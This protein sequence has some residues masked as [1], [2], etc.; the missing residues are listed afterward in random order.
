VALLTLGAAACGDDD[1]ATDAT[2][3]AAA[4]SEAESDS[5][6]EEAPAPA[7][8]SAPAESGT[9][10]GALEGTVFYLMPNATTPRYVNSD[11]PAIEAALAQYAP[12]MTLELLNAEGDPQKQVQQAET[13]ISRGAKAIILTAAD[14]NLSAGVLEKAAEA[15]VPVIAYEHEAL[16]GPLDYFVVFSPYSAGKQ[17]AEYFASQIADGTLSSPVKLAR[18]YG[19][20]GD[21]Y[22]E[23]MLRGQNEILQP[24]IDDGTIQVV[25]EDNVPQWD[26][27]EAQ[28]LMEQCLT[29]TQN[30]I[31]AVLGFYD[32]ITAGAIAAMEPQG[33]AGVVPVYGGQNPELSGLQYM[34]KGYQ[35]DNIAKPYSVEADAAVQLVV[36][37]VTGEPPAA[38]LINEEFD[39]GFGAIPTASLAVTHFLVDGIQG[40]VDEGIFTWEEICTGPAEGTE[41]CAQQLAG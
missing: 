35:V 15:G 14:P 37:A 24:L 21:N 36:A 32:G 1:D 30:D 8:T 20:A 18:L 16:N 6:A 5:A 28:S 17:Q 2:D 38:G 12:N 3:A 9:A 4:E 27:A 31:T 7:E 33:L 19:N 39:N 26:P 25:C 23:E 29:K 40:V 22:N 34:L 41:V 11:A 10:T 13:A